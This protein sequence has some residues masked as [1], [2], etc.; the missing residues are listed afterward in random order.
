LRSEWPSEQ[1]IFVEKGLILSMDYFS[2]MCAF[3]RA[4]DLGSFSKVAA[5]E[6]IKVSTVSRYITAWRP[7]WGPLFSIARSAACT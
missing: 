2:S 6:G 7:T 5:E 4:V 3:V 1:I